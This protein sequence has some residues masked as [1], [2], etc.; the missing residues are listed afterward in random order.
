MRVFLAPAAATVS[1]LDEPARDAVVLDRTLGQAMASELAA[2]GLERV[3]V[4][5][6]EE[7][8]SRARAEAEGAFVLLDSVIASRVVVQRFVK[9]ARTRAGSVALVCALPKGLGIDFLSHVEGLDPSEPKGGGAAVWTAPFYFLRGAAV[10][11][12][13]AEPLVLPYKEQILR[14]PVPVAVLG[15]SEHVVGMSESYL[16]NVSHWVHVLRVNTAAIAGWWFDRLRWGVVLGPAWIAWRLLSGFP[17]RGGRLA[18]GMKSVSWSAKVHH[19]AHLE[20]SIVKRKATIGAHATVRNSFIDEGANIGDGAR[21][22]GSVIGKGAFVATNAIVFG[23]VVYPEAFAA[24]H[25]VQASILGR[26]S[27]VLAASYFFDVNFFR[28]IRV[29]HRGKLMDC[30]AQFLGVCVG[31]NTRVGAGVWVGS[32][33]EIPKNAL[34]VRPQ[35]DV[36]MRIGDVEPNV[37]YTV[38][39]GALAK[40]GGG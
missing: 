24:Q 3:N 15:S 5:S 19:S 31:P 25:I 28:N 37:P 21:I 22:F 4:A 17:W 38:R 33:R 13:S 39:G 30:G 20:L 23:A 8:E 29:P 7:G 16:C 27:C 11:L 35:D 18:G 6:L 32:G 10:S 14:F 12:A 34:L 36:A 40:L 26:R 9:A 2:V 1:P